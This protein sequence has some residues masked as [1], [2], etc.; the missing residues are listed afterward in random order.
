MRLGSETVDSGGHTQEEG[1]RNHNEREGDV[2]GVCDEQDVGSNDGNGMAA[3]ASRRDQVERSRQSAMCVNESKS[4]RAGSGQAH[5]D[6][7]L[8]RLQGGGCGRW[9]SVLEDFR[10]G[11]VVKR[12]S[13]EGKAAAAAAPSRGDVQEGSG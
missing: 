7:G 11:G 6:S 9:G 1:D 2:E 5:V 3:I 8:H 10:W 13:G 4:I 12:G